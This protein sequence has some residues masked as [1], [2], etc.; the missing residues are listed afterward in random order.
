MEL[1]ISILINFFENI[2]MK[3]ANNIGHMSANS[4]FSDIS[5]NFKIRILK[6]KR[7]KINKAGWELS[8]VMMQPTIFSRR[9]LIFRA[10]LSLTPE[11]KMKH[12]L[13][14]LLILFLF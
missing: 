11:Y 6:E 9:L 12:I 4:W 7:I 10:Y 1:V 3:N 13:S 2:S 14:K 8:A 5:D